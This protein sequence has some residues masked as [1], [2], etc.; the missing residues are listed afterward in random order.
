[1]F[2]I[3]KIVHNLCMTKALFNKIN[4]SAP[5]SENGIIFKEEIVIP[6]AAIV[7]ILLLVIMVGVI[8][9]GLKKCTNTVTGEA[10]NGKLPQILKCQ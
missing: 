8:A 5:S 1:M 10:Q 9:L 3:K 4:S 2:N 7:V 6:L